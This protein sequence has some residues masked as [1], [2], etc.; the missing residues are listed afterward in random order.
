V[1]RTGRR[2][3]AVA[4]RVVVTIVGGA[5]V[6][7]AMSSCSRTSASHGSQSPTPASDAVSAAAALTSDDE[8]AAYATAIAEV[9]AYLDTWSR[10][11]STKAAAIYNVPEQQAPTDAAQDWKD[12][13]ILVSGKVVD[14][15]PYAW[16]SSGQFTLMVTMDL[17]FTG[18][19]PAASAWAEGRNSQ[20]VTFR[21]PNATTKYRMSWATGP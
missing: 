7:A 17:H 12:P 6:V 18:A 14:Y 4:T 16:V 10:Q 1:T 3:V 9:D 11:G 5:L 13:L 20:V 19:D 8:H 2:A 21:G 15:R